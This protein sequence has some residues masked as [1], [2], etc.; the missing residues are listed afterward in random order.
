MDLYHKNLKK[1]GINTAEDKK[2]ILNNDLK[3]QI[4]QKDIADR[5][6]ILDKDK[7]IN[8]QKVTT[9][10]KANDAEYLQ[11]AI[12]MD[13]HKEYTI[14]FETLPAYRL[15]QENNKLKKGP[16]H[17]KGCKN[18]WARKKWTWIQSGRVKKAEKLL[19]KHVELLSEYDKYK[20]DRISELVRNEANITSFYTDQEQDGKGVEVSQMLSTINTS[21]AR[22]AILNLNQ[23]AAES[24]AEL[25]TFIKNYVIDENNADAERQ[26][27]TEKDQAKR[28]KK[29]EKTGHEAAD[30]EII[31]NRENLENELLNRE[32]AKER[33][34]KTVVKNLTGNVSVQLKDL[35]DLFKK[36]LS[37][38]Q[39]PFTET[40]DEGGKT[41]EK[42]L[43]AQRYSGMAADANKI[44]DYAKDL[45][46]AVPEEL[47]YIIQLDDNAIMKNGVDK[48]NPKDHANEAYILL[49]AAASKVFYD[50]LNRYAGYYVT[51]GLEKYHFSKDKERIARNYDIFNVKLMTHVR[52]I[53]D[54]STAYAGKIKQNRVKIFDETV[55]EDQLQDMNMRENIAIVQGAQPTGIEEA[56]KEEI[57]ENAQEKIY[58]EWRNLL[59]NDIRGQ[60]E[61]DQKD[62][63]QTPWV[64]KDYQEQVFNIMKNNP[65]CKGL[66]GKPLMSYLIA[67]NDNLR[68]SLL[69][70]EDEL[71]KTSVG[72]KFRYIPKLRDEFIEKIKTERFAMLLRPDFFYRDLLRNNSVL[73]DLFDRPAVKAAKNRQREIMKAINEELGMDFYTNIKHLSTLWSNEAMQNILL[74]VPSDK[75]AQE[76][77]A[78][79]QI[80]KKDKEG[81]KKKGNVLKYAIQ[82][83]LGNSLS[84]GVSDNEFKQTIEKIKATVHDNIAV[85]DRKIS[86]MGICD[87]AKEALK[88]SLLKRMGGE[89]LLGYNII[90]QDIV[91]YTIDNMMVFDGTA[92][93]IQRTWERKFARTGLPGRLSTK[94]ERIVSEKIN[95]KGKRDEYYLR[96]EGFKVSKTSKHKWKESNDKTNAVINSLK[97]LYNNDIKDF[98]KNYTESDELRQSVSN[99]GLLY[100]GDKVKLSKKQWDQIE[101]Y[102]EN[103]WLEVFKDSYVNGEYSSKDVKKKLN[104]IKKGLSQVINAQLTKNYDQREALRNDASAL[105]EYEDT[106]VTR[107]E[108][109]D[110]LSKNAVL[111]EPKIVVT[112][113]I[114]KQIFSDPALKN[115]L[116]NKED[117]DIFNQVLGEEL[118]DEKSSIHA[119]FAYLD[120]VRSIEQLGNL[121]LIDYSSFF[122]ELKSILTVTDAGD[123]Q[124]EQRLLLDDWRMSGQAGADT[125]G[126]KKKLLKDFFK[127]GLTRSILSAN[128]KKYEEEAE[129]AV[130]IDS[131]RIDAYLNTEV[132]EEDTN[133]KFNYLNVVGKTVNQTERMKK[134]S[135]AQKLW[136]R[137]QKADE[138]K[139]G[140]GSDLGYVERFSK[141]INIF[142]S[143]LQGK[144]P[145]TI[146]K[147][148]K[149]LGAL[150]DS[151]EITENKQEGKISEYSMPP[152][153][154]EAFLNA[155]FMKN[156]I[157]SIRDA[158]MLK[159]VQDIFKGLAEEDP[160]EKKMTFSDFMGEL[161]LFGCGKEYFEAGGEGEKTFLD[162]KVDQY[163]ADILKN[164][165]DFYKRRAQIDQTLEAY[166]V[167]QAERTRI[168]AR[169]RPVIAGLKDTTDSKEKAENVS[170]YGVANTKALL[171]KLTEMYSGKEEDRAAS[172]AKSKEIAELYKA[173]K[174]YIDSYGTGFEHGK[175]RVVRD[176]MFRDKE[177]WRR[178]MSMSDSE[179]VD[180]IEEQNRLYGKGLDVFRSID[181]RGSGPINELYVMNNWSDFKNRA[182]WDQYKWRASIDTFHTGFLQKKV[183]GKKGASV[184]SILDSVEKK[185]V[186][187]GYDTNVKNSKNLIRLEAIMNSDPAAFNLMYNEEDMLEACKRVD[188]QYN[189]NMA[190]LKDILTGVLA[191][192]DKLYADNEEDDRLYK[193][194]AN[195]YFTGEMVAQKLDAVNSAARLR[196]LEEEAKKGK[197][198]TDDDRLYADYSLLLQ[199]IRPYAYTSKTGDF[200]KNIFRKFKE[201]K[202]AQKS[203]SNANIYSD[204]NVLDTKDAIRLELEIK[205]NEGKMLERQFNNELA[206]YR[207]KKA[208]LGS[209]LL[210]AYNAD[211]KFDEK[212]V[213]KA[214]SFVEKNLSG[215]FGAA[216]EEFIKGLLTERAVAFGMNKKEDD[217]KSVLDSE[218]LRL[219][220]LDKALRD[221]GVADED[222]IKKALV[223]GLAQNAV[224]VELPLDGTH[225]GDVKEILDE[226]KAREDAINI[227]EPVS[228]IAKRDY[229]E[230]MDEMD[231]AR[232]TMKKEEFKAVCDK[233]R[234]Y[235]E[236]VD[237]A[238]EKINAKTA[239]PKEQLGLF[240]YFKKDI[241]EALAA[242]KNVDE[243]TGSITEQLDRLIGDKT[244]A[245]NGLDAESIRTITL[246]YLP[247]SS[248]LMQHISD[249]SLSAEEKL[250]SSENYN[251]ADIEREISM[252][253]NKDLIKQYNNLTRD[254]QKVFAIA[255]TFPDIALTESEKFS[256]STAIRDKDKEYK[257]E[258]ELQDQ[259]ASYIYDQDFAPRIDY[260]VVMSRLMK[261]DRKTGLRRVSVTM[262]EKAYK[263]T[264]FCMM[265]KI[266][267]RPKDFDKLSDG[268]T[269]GQIGRALAGRENENAEVEKALNSKE[270]YGAKTFRDYFKSFA[271]DDSAKDKS[272]AK[273]AERFGQMNNV[274]MNMLLH[275]LQDRT[276]IDYT[277]NTGYLS[278]LML[279]SVPFVNIERREAIKNS[280][281]RPDG[282]D[283]YFIAELNRSIT[284]EMF[285][286]AA[287]NLFSYQLRD[288]IDLRNK[289]ISNNSFSKEALSRVTNI[290]WKMLER[291]MDLVK[292][293]EEENLRIQLC[294][295]TTE[296]TTDPSSPNVK[297]KV[298]GK[299]IEETFRG[300]TTNVSDLFNDSLT[301]EA[302]N[303]ETL[304]YETTNHFDFFNDFLTREAKKNPDVAMPMISAFSG[305]SDNEKMLVVHAL[306][307][308]DILDI[309]T[310]GTVT[311]ALGQNENRYVNEIGRDQLADYYIDHFSTPG[312]TAVM[313]TTQYDVRD[314]MKSLVSTQVS[315]ARDTKN[316]KNFA[317]M[318]EGKKILNWVYVGGRDTGVDWNLFANALKFVK[319]TEGER[320]L[321][322]G[323]AEAY[324]SAGDISNYG[325]FMYNYSFLRKNQ[326]RSGYRF[327]RFL[328]R[329]VRAEL[330]A[331]IPGY[332]VGQRIMQ[333]V[334][335]PKM[336]NKMLSSGFVKPGVSRNQTS[337]YLGYATTGGSLIKMVLG[338]F[339]SVGGAIGGEALQQTSSGISG[340]YNVGLSVK[341]LMTVDNPLENAAELEKE[342]Q[343]KNGQAA[344]MQTEAQKLVT[345][346]N[347]INKDWILNEVSGVAVKSAN[348]RDIIETATTCL[349]VLS[350]ASFGMSAITNFFSGGI[351]TVVLEILHTA[352]FVMS[353]FQDK[354]MMDRYF[355]DDGPLGKEIQALKDE[356]IQKII[357][358]QNLRKE[359]GTRHLM[360][361]ASIRKSETEFMGKMSNAEL[362]R[363]AYGFKDFSEQASFVGWNI[364]QTLMQ[365][366]SPYG[367]DPV[368]FMRAALLLS[369][370]GCKDVIGK[371]DNESA[372]WVYN[373]LMGQDIR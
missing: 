100:I 116:K 7:L 121:G 230:F 179:F 259:L 151:A 290:D 64:L 161:L 240:D 197:K 138:G 115:I 44:L 61:V 250:M 41:V 4:I 117:R 202:K 118:R 129:K 235:F 372:Q 91:E 257:K 137:L 85:I 21:L 255:L 308:R 174:D 71:P 331:A 156:D 82:K 200:A 329:R 27:K 260:N 252:S 208:V 222:L 38:S 12:D 330:E 36:V 306:K 2:N 87:T 166:D 305:M 334:L 245:R 10:L 304:R 302:K 125:Y 303:E 218:K 77:F 297:A 108:F 130:S 119:K 42:S 11:G 154:Q 196:K 13:L 33:T 231:I 145:S 213:S 187:A 16:T 28:K 366:C 350:G 337:A 50:A 332:G 19:E 25:D 273:I 65:D 168:L 60:V 300:E 312:Q 188:D 363:K 341:S 242:E 177:T 249:K 338:T 59:A 15:E 347:K 96:P 317:D 246:T 58:E 369:A 293:I 102:F 315:D 175:F 269:T 352:R 114:E 178:I 14:T 229:E 320:K 62:M 283:H 311:T 47:Y 122:S 276:A 126:V 51:D 271:K 210:F 225:E 193:E 26:K 241:F 206:D 198:L 23:S 170:K 354:K 140:D 214:S 339:K 291:A 135:Y 185:M 76:N 86:L 63:K 351:K 358:D 164:S 301:R 141:F 288:D 89:Y 361:D 98:M 321:L 132:N 266:E 264:Q 123:N 292:E 160:A 48:F 139:H 146:K 149:K 163:N 81:V 34:L 120:D 227:K 310:E 194:I 299:E 371:Q 167:P 74:S 176:F 32:G 68:S 159:A 204:R 355:A 211:P 99:P 356:N 128:A 182:D 296:H 326:Y 150:F 345:K 152:E 226:L 217:L 43:S 277:T 144:K 295:Q 274:Q 219:L 203:E 55:P 181:F 171:E 133:I 191:K 270:Y 340:L 111:E 209:V 72:A 189:A 52:N 279:E 169:L 316:K 112:D 280:F 348:S 20:E 238:V 313:A 73:D 109:T 18:W 29:A 148:I 31:Q 24:M 83:F 289:A 80:L 84:Y 143:N 153:T 1:K 124:A 359:T 79:E 5:N 328:G 244:E 336:R 232:Y 272:V 243:L 199:V 158:A 258:I 278:A 131:M 368:Q 261:T 17:L 39:K 220:A 282:M 357:D 251:R 6:K 307:H 173:R 318:M 325:R 254:E 237:A 212:T 234:R 323:E 247:D 142:V 215:D 344:K 95:A 49:M 69:Q 162:S 262:F 104:G 248:V 46:I 9:G 103:S 353:I 184:Q 67:M 180:Y 327:T 97:K 186:D 66:T 106:L 93:A 157:L 265:K 136:Y 22:D 147:R 256:S 342:R 165:T 236:F 3:N 233:K 364:V 319:R 309:S 190:S 57:K 267:M 40:V 221:A 192:G 183:G 360:D 92:A 335:S 284:H 294:R 287:E 207:E 35:S 216:D 263:Y 155:G 113:D 224:R 373:R 343:E 53:R 285:E 54:M 370:I 30:E 172:Q 101:D 88:R 90:S 286:R 75:E 8:T 367:T 105:R 201:F 70:L 346:D 223:F 365:A 239:K 298:L 205:K 195:L 362:F 127:G 78:M 314:A 56:K 37:D 45:G 349:D 333:A 322:Q 324:R 94:M 268:R 107:D 253:G 281:M 228:K 110:G 275:I 134:L